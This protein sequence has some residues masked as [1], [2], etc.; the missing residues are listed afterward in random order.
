MDTTATTALL[1]SVA[2]GVVFGLTKSTLWPC[3]ERI[4]PSPLKTSL[5]RLPVD[6]LKQLVYQPDQF[7]GA[8]D[9][10]TPVR[11]PKTVIQRWYQRAI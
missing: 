3:R 8:R 5:P 4:L 11:C 6:E 9:V 1:T 7:P 2:L 10:E